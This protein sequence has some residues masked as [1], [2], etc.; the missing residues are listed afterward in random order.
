MRFVTNDAAPA[1]SATDTDGGEFR[2]TAA[3]ERPVYLSFFRYASCPFCN[4]RVHELIESQGLLAGTD[5]VLVFPSTLENIRAYAGKQRPPFRIVPDPEQ[6]L[7]EL[8]RVESR[9]GGVG[10]A[11]RKAPALIRAMFSHRF[12]PGAVEGDLNRI[13][14]EFVIDAGGRFVAAFYGEDIADHMPL[15]EL[16]G[17][18]RAA[19]K[20]DRREPQP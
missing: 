2:L 6:R 4:L 16:S 14:A 13:P 7:Y 5:V 20:P 17:H 9:W 12:L 1:F 8:Y 11:V 3:L 15:A 10:K 18:L 19:Q